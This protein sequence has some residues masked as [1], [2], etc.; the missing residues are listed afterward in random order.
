[1]T[2]R[3]ADLHVHTSFSDGT[4]SPAEVVRH[5][6]KI[7]LAA[8]AITDH[9]SV[10][11]IGP[12]LEAAKG[13]DLEIIPAIEFTTE[14]DGHE[15]HVLGY[16]IDYP[17]KWL[18]RELKNLLQLRQK[19]M[20]KMLKRLS[21]FGISISMDDVKGIAG[22]GSL[23]RLHLA[24]VLLKKGHV[25]SLQEAFSRFLG[26]GKPCYVR[27]DRINPVK[28]IS[29]IAKLGGVSV[30]AHPHTLEMDDLIPVFVKAGLKGIEA[31]HTDHSPAAVQKY[32]KMA[33]EFGLLITGGSDCHGM[34]K[35][36]ILMGGVTVPYE[37]VEQ[38]KVAAR[39]N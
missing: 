39:Q 10:D 5:A 7:G 12:S 1:M 22:K 20:Q 23:G 37:V 11:G 30:L 32:E 27:G 9:D 28:A 25:S 14:A 36:K 24:L 16:F 4:F 35:G 13:T 21:G 15:V 34:G 31:Y 33:E 38:L 29:M 26:N 8:I 19:R 17:Q 6:N 2:Q 3:R 18:V